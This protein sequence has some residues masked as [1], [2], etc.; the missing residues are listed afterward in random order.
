MAD[1]VMERILD[2]ERAADERIA[3]AKKDAADTV[4]QAEADA[5]MK[6]DGEARIAKDAVAVAAKKAREKASA[7]ADTH[8]KR[9]LAEARR[10]IEAAAPNRDRAIA[11]VVGEIIGQ[12]Q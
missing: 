3:A 2:A 6:L 4:A 10:I 1:S 11:V 8:Q 12:W 5:R 9:A 7:I